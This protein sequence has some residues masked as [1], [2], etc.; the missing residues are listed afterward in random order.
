LLKRAASGWRVGRV[1]TR[2]P[3]QQDFEECREIAGDLARFFLT[4][5]I[6]RIE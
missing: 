1:G 5:E 2:V 4:L 3:F 6:W